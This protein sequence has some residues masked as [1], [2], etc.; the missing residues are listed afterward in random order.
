MPEGV[1]EL[2]EAAD[3]A[4]GVYVNGKHFAS[5]R[6]LMLDGD[7]AVRIDTVF[8]PAELVAPGDGGRS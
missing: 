4:V 1:V 8:R 6:L 5:G 7:W 2:E 3:D